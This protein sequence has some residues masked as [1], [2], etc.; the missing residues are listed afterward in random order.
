MTS[1][2][3][4]SVVMKWWREGL[5]PSFDEII[6][7]NA[8]GCRCENG[9]NAYDMSSLPRIAFLGD[10]V[11]R[12]PT[13]AKRIWIDK[14]IQMT[15]DDD[16]N[17]LFFFAWALNVPDDEL[18]DISRSVKDFK[19]QYQAFFDD[20]LITFTLTQIE[21]AVDY[22]LNGNDDLTIDELTEDEKQIRE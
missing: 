5:T 9:T 6:E 11:L 10:Y 17:R 22:V 8:L 16:L 3:A 21:M 18:P 2:L 19:R 1:K 20:V 14:A 15:G 13:V 4:K 7:L 12:E